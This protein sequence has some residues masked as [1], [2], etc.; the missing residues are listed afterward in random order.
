M[1]KFNKG[2]KVR[3]IGRYCDHKGALGFVDYI[4]PGSINYPYRVRISDGGAV[5]A[6]GDNDL[7]LVEPESL[8]GKLVKITVEGLVTTY[9]PSN[10]YAIVD[11]KHGVLLNQPGVSYEVLPDPVVLPT[12]QNALIRAGTG[13]YRLVG[14]RWF[15]TS[16]AFFDTETVLMWARNNANYR[17]IF[18]GEDCP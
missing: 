5:F 17:V 12:K 14:D 13:V 8:V 11:E 16:G 9:Y 10:E 6:Y 4:W 2:D 3:V 18:E 7:E 1:S 15:D